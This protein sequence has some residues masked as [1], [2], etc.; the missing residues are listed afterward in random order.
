MSWSVACS[1]DSS[2]IACGLEDGG[3]KIFD[4]KTFDVF[5][6][7]PA[8]DLI[9]SIRF[10]TQQQL[11]YTKQD[12]TFG[13]RDLT[14]QAHVL[15]FKYDGFGRA[16][17]SDGKS[18]ASGNGKVVQLWQTDITIDCE[19]LNQDGRRSRVYCVAFSGDGHLIASGSDDWSVKV[20]DAATGLCLHTFHGQSNWVYEFTFS[21]DSSFCA[22]ASY[23]EIRIWDL[24]TG[25]LIS[26]LETDSRAIRFS[27]DSS[28][29]LCLSLLYPGPDHLTLWEAKTGSLLAKVEVDKEFDDEDD[30][31]FGVDGSSVILQS[32]HS[33]K[34]WQISPAPFSDH[35]LPTRTNRNNHSSPPMVF[36]PMLDDQQ[37]STPSAIV[38]HQYRYEVGNGWILDGQDRHVLW[39]PPNLKGHAS[40]CYG[41][42]VVVGCLTGKV[43]LVDFSDHQV[44]HPV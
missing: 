13:I 12:S 9:T 26:T 28:Q 3:V 27:P 21:P 40:D 42:K 36:V 29:L 10:S 1:A 20:W 5:Q 38:P 4:A 11:M 18:I 15:L 30:V 41:K 2:W 43:I 22:S 44:E 6:T 19:D 35:N 23:D 32:R 34:R 24:R 16:M 39:I 8:S 7:I 33:V 14:K 17:S 31:A 25:T 37:H